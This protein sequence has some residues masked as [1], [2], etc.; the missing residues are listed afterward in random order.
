MTTSLLTL[1]HINVQ[2]NDG[3]QQRTCR[4]LRLNKELKISHQIGMVTL[5]KVE[6]HFH[7]RIR[8]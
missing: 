1:A 4:T 3:S 2:H 8:L 5:G 6:M 7:L